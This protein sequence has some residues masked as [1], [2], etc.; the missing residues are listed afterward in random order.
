MIS[1]LETRTIIRRD[2]SYDLNS[3]HDPRVFLKVE[4]FR[5]QPDPEMAGKKDQSRNVSRAQSFAS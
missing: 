3:N 1:Q 2:A 5:G 4:E